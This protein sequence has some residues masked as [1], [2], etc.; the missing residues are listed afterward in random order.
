MELKCYFFKRTLRNTHSGYGVAATSI[1]ECPI[2]KG[3]MIGSIPCINKN[4]CK[5]HAPHMRIVMNK[6]SW[7]MCEET[8]KMMDENSSL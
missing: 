6:F 3:I 7:V 1:E 8:T 4:C 5:G 2:H